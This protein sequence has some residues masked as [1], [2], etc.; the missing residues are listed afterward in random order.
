[1]RVGECINGAPAIRSVLFK[2]VYDC[3]RV[4]LPKRKLMASMSFKFTMEE[5]KPIFTTASDTMA[6]NTTVSSIYSIIKLIC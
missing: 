1:M 3:K 5:K 4:S 2:R 6:T